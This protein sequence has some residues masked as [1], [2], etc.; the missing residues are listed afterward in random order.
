M[1]NRVHA[2]YHLE[3]APS[4]IIGMKRGKINYI[5]YPTIDHLPKYPITAK[6]NEGNL[7]NLLKDVQIGDSIV[8]EADPVI[9]KRQLFHIRDEAWGELETVVDSIEE[10]KEY[11]RTIKFRINK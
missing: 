6:D 3:R 11:T 5:Q 10:S 9:L 8:F 1:V 7:A 4:E 2:I